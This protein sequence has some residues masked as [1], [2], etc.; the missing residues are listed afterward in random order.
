MITFVKKSI[1][2][3]FMRK[4]VG[5]V[6]GVLGVFFVAPNLSAQSSV[7]DATK[8]SD[9]QLMTLLEEAEKRGLTEND[10]EKLAL[11]RGYSAQDIAVIRER[12]TRLRA[13]VS[14]QSAKTMSASTREQLG[15]LSE[16]VVTEDIDKKEVVQKNIQALAPFGKAIF[17][18]PRMTFEANLRIPTPKDYLLG[19]DDQLKVYISGYAF[20]QYD[21]T[22]SNEGTVR[23][24]SLAPIYVNGLTVDQAKQKIEDRLKI[25][26]GGLRNGSLNLDMSLGSVRSIKVTL[27]GEVAR[28]G[29]YTVSSLSTL[30]NALY[31]AGGPTNQG[32]M[33]T[34]QLVRQNKVVKTMDL[35]DFLQSGLMTDNVRL[36][37]QDVIRIPLATT[38]V[39]LHGEVRK[40][41]IFELK[42]GENIQQLLQYAGGFTDR[43]Y[44]ASM[45]LERYTSREKTF[46]T[47]REDQFAG[48]SLQDGDKISVGAILDRF[49]NRLEISGAVFRPGFFALTEESNSV[50]KLVQ[51]AE[52]LREDAFSR[53]VLI[54]RVKA[55]GDPEL[56]SVNLQAIL[57]GTEPDFT[58][59]R[60]DMVLV[61]SITE[62]REVRSVE[63][64]G[65]VV[66]PGEY[67]YSDQL[68][69]SDLVILAG[70]FREGASSM[71]VEIAR[72]MS[73]EEKQPLS[74][75]VIELSVD[76]RFSVAAKEITLRPFDLVFVRELPNYRQQQIIQVTGEVL[77]PGGYALSS[78][79]D[80]ITDILSRAGGVR[81]SAFIDA[82]TLFRN[83]RTIG[84]RFD[85]IL[86]NPESPENLIL[87]N[88]DV[89]NIPRNMNVVT[90]GG[91][92]LSPTV[93][94]Y[95]PSYRFSD[96]ISTAGGYTD[97]ARVK[98]SFVKYAN[99]F[100]ARTRSFLGVKSYP[101]I[102]QGA[103]IIVPKHQRRNNL[104][105][106]DV[107]ALTSSLV[108]LS[109]VLTTLIRTL[110]QP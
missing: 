35:Y 74:T 10:V 27:I 89:V 4:L 48:F 78:R 24:E 15:E 73:G 11:S 50:K 26:F 52:G 3:I 61:K 68:T 36:F 54:R 2:H 13:G 64:R 44:R 86:A 108:S 85:K 42:A 80:R 5:I 34:I 51:L 93:V 22:V 16:R 45:S 58:L 90:I 23:I 70:G 101:K 12:L 72:R 110:N 46:G 55:N 17:N 38:Q 94:A 75:Q 109:L 91:E 29:T 65:A 59:Q 7:P 77:Y 56:I 18:N 92:V 9:Q 19:P 104:G 40:P 87:E 88:G 107:I 14:N 31:V 62:L 37:D 76:S 57:T 82:A 81:E 33:R 98:K 53:R 28:P 96:Y 105:K 84:V 8:V 67:E 60:E 83:G 32:S 69:V 63:I 106:A 39:A 97:S 79:T 20:Q 25:L 30:F 1:D 49:E 100:T 6:L 99:G 95:Q 43:A 41:A 47:I 103:M 21:L 66:N 71:R 102:K